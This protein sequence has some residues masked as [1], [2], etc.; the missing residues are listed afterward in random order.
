MRLAGGVLACVSGRSLSAAQASTMEMANYDSAMRRL[1]LLQ[2][3]LS[4]RP[5]DL[6]VLERRVCLQYSPPEAHSGRSC[7]PSQG[8]CFDF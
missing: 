3:H 8:K 7:A 6:P 2:A 1:L 5:E 4:E